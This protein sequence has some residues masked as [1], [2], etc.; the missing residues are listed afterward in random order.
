M[1][2]A[3]DAHAFEADF[4]T[5]AMIIAG[6]EKDITFNGLANYSENKCGCA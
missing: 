3:K 4:R 2:L 5:A 6:Q 1:E